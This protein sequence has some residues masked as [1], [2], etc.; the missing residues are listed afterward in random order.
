MMQN[1]RMVDVGNKDV[2]RRRAIARGS[3]RLSSVTMQMIAKGD[4]PKG[5]IL[6]IAE[7][8][9]IMAAKNT[10]NMLPLCH[11]LVLD[12]VRIWFDIGSNEVHANCEV[13]CNAK[14]GVEMEAL[15][16]LNIC[17]LAI[18]D[19]AKAID[20]IIEISEIYLQKK[21]GG[22]SGLWSHPKAYLATS[23]H[24]L[25]DTS[26]EGIKFCVG[27]LSD[28]ASQ[29]IYQDESGALLRNF[30]KLRGGAEEFYKIIPDEA[31]SLRKLVGATL[32]KKSNV[33][34]LTGGTGISNRDITPDIIK[35][36]S[37]KELLGFGELQRQFGSQFTKTSWLSRAS[38]YVVKETLV[39]LFPG[40]P[41]AVKQGL[42]CIGT[43][44]PHAV[45]MLRG[46]S[47]HKIEEGDS[48]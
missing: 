38:A 29:G 27:T 20:P 15:T 7:V 44:I 21:E 42:E 47:H 8:A 24:S 18:Y 41:K 6:A 37:S 12:S 3:I 32:E 11:P 14:T 48:N 1:Y 2:T 36:M 13:I 10:S 35:D 25:R 31:E 17:L 19:L 23:V 22:K 4:S 39:V 45:K 30:C 34:L 9:G 43:L 28:R 16:G 40:S 5:N 33:L 26:F 46:E